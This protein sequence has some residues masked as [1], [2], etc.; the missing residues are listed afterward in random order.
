M[1]IN[2]GGRT[3]GRRQWKREVSPLLDEMPELLAILKEVREYDRVRLQRRIELLAAHLQSRRDCH[4]EIEQFIKLAL[5][6]KERSLVGVAERLKIEYPE[7]L[8]ITAHRQE[9]LD[10]LKEN[11]VIVVCGST[12]SGKTT[13]LPKIALD[14]GRGRFGAIG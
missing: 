3:G 1:A 12:G 10:A 14:L 9:I 6:A 13:Q 2:G 7:N 8:P 5:K 11:Q 4:R